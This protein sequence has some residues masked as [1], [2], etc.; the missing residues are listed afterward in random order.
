MN[1][2][3]VIDFFYDELRREGQTRETLFL[4][5]DESAVAKLKEKLHTDVQI[6]DLHPLAN[7]CIAN[8]WL[9]R[10]TADPGYK[11]LSLTDAGLKMALEYQYKQRRS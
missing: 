5:L 11:Y 4:T 3:D 6:T 9:E 10:T 8:E 2:M 7:I 1:E